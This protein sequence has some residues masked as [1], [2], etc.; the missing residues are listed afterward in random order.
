[1]FTE[2]FLSNCHSMIYCLFPAFIKNAF[3]DNSIPG[4]KSKLH[5]HK[6]LNRKKTTTLSW[7]SK[8]I[9]AV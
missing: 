6:Q 5:V 3:A 1:M 2:K 8:C 7:L 4:R 9:S